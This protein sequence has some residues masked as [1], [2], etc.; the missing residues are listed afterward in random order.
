MDNGRKALDYSESLCI[1]LMQSYKDT[2]MSEWEV[3]C[4]DG[5]MFLNKRSTLMCLATLKQKKKKK[6]KTVKA[7]CFLWLFQD[8]WSQSLCFCRAETSSTPAWCWATLVPWATSCTT[9]RPQW[10][11]AC[12]EPPRPC[13][14][15][16]AWLSLLPLEVR[17]THLASPMCHFWHLP[18]K[19]TYHSKKGQKRPNP[20]TLGEIL[21]WNIQ[22]TFDKKLSRFNSS[23][24]F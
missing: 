13:P 11:W 5:W 4:N 21:R 23:I 6:G 10:A 2:W 22:R 12:W 19:I 18:M 24:G 3:Y 8:C 1:S 15:S 14:P 17:H 20:S 9:R 7:L 16:W